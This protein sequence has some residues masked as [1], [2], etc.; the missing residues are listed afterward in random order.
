MNINNNDKKDNLNMTNKRML[1]AMHTLGCKVNQYETEAIKEQFQKAGHE[2]VKE[3]EFADVYIINT[4][5]VT[6]LA[7]R[8]SRQYIRRMKKVNPYSIVVVTGCYVQISP[9]EVSSIEGVNIVAGINE[10]GNLLKYVEDYINKSI[11]TQNNSS[12]NGCEQKINEG[13]IGTENLHIMDYEK[14]DEYIET[15]CITSM[16][17]RTR[18]YIKIQEGCNRFCS[19]CI[20][21]YAR[22]KVRSRS[23]EAVVKE[24]ETLIEKG[25]K[26]IILTGI[27][28]ALYGTEEGFVSENSQEQPIGKEQL[29]GIQIIISRINAIPGEFRIRLSS[30]EPTVINAEYVKKL[31]KYEKLCPHLHLSLQSGSDDVLKMMNRRYDREEYLEIVKVLKEFDANYGITTDIIAGFPGETEENFRESLEMIRKVGFCKV[32]AFNYSKRPGTKAAEMKGHLAPDIKKR[33][34]TE[35]NKTGEKEAVEF[36]KRNI[37]NVRKVL[38][39]ELDKETGMITGYTDNYIKVYV[40]LSSFDSKSNVNLSSFDSKSNVNLSSVNSNNNVIDNETCNLENQFKDVK[41]TEIFRDGMK[42]KIVT[43]FII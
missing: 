39:E 37:G 40:N 7:D 14:L 19:Y 34:V 18:A 9:E 17:S 5:T 41:L 28:T 15:G 11:S 32:H 43:D 36:C 30:L 26:E 24:A 4:C 27:N 20:I 6:G 21:P 16:E 35:L 3:D 42:G 13:K 2:I 23:A 22:G 25:F 8:K 31:L 33:R 10:K 38:F 1:I 29:T 12:I